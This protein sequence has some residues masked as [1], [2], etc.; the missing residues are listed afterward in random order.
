[1]HPHAHV[2]VLES[3]GSI[4]GVWSAER[5]YPGL[6]SNN[7]LGTYEF[8][9]FPMDPLT[10]GVRPGQHIPGHVLHEYLTR[11]ARRFGLFDRIRLGRKVEV[12]EHRDGGG[13]LLTV[14]ASPY[15][16]E[17]ARREQLVARK[18]VVAT[19]LTSEA[20]LP[21][22]AGQEHFEAPLFH[23]KDFARHEETLRTATKVVVYGGTKSAWDAVYAYGMQGIKVHWVI[24]GESVCSSFFP[25]LSPFVFCLLLYPFFYPFKV[26]HEVH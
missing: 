26:H 12:A 5:L 7:M 11:F 10:F 24:R 15:G 4:G 2:V 23:C 14:A 1:M 20:F 17:A 25:V 13:W 19:G 22:I 9:D 6:Q 18:L 3:A 16:E 8:S 21:D